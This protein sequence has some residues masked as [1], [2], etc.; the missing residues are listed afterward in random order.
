M[1]NVATCHRTSQS[2]TA[3]LAPTV[4]LM[5]AIPASAR[6]G[7]QAVRSLPASSTRN[8]NASMNFHHR[9]SQSSTAKL[10]PTVIMMG[11]TPAFVRMGLRGVRRLP[12]SKT[13]SRNAWMKKNLLLTTRD[14]PLLMFLKWIPASKWFVKQT[15][16]ASLV[17]AA[18]KSVQRKMTSSPFA[19][20]R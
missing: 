13:R 14:A 6:M 9:T 16:T 19:L 4:I 18:A 5:D 7:L 1:P 10:A 3:K 20:P 2:S 11:A 17:V 8:R 12:V 15:T